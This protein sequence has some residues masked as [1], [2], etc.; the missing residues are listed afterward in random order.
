[1]RYD[2]TAVVLHWVIGIAILA[3]FTLGHWMHDLP[4][5]AD[6]VRAW[7]FNLH[8]STG[9]VLGVL[10]VLRLLWRLSHPVAAQVLPAWQR[11][12]ASF[13]H[14]GLYACMLAL[15]LSGFLGS[16]FSGYRIKLFGL[17]L[18]KLMQAWPAGAD[19]MHE[20]HE[21]AGWIFAALVGVHVLAALW[22]ALRRDGVFQRMWA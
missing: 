15:P 21:T 9:M 16:V 12:A 3:Q 4:K 22:H 11:W 2:R 20:A 6:G 1:M 18:P 14:Y 8:K 5:D 13:A 7:W 19:F 17:G 10:I